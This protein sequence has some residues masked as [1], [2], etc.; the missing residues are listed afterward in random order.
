MINISEPAINRFMFFS[1][2]RFVESNKW[3][4]SNSVKL[5]QSTNCATAKVLLVSIRTIERSGIICLVA[6]RTAHCFILSCNLQ[7]IL[8]RRCFWANTIVLSLIFT[9]NGSI[10]DSLLDTCAL[11]CANWGHTFT[12]V[13]AYL[14][15]F[16]ILDLFGHFLIKFLV[17]KIFLIRIN[18]FWLNITFCL[19]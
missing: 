11:H 12:E 15:F 18:F 17:V 13:I 16:K 9:L 19:E 2:I 8:P 7:F 5:R 10:W 1:S 6:L 14:R 4:I 3:S